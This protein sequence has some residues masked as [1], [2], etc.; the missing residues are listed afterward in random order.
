MGDTDEKGPVR[1][2]RRAGP[3]QGYLLSW[4]ECKGGGGLE[5]EV[6]QTCHVRR[7][8]GGGEAVCAVSSASGHL[9]GRSIIKTHKITANLATYQASL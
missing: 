7:R 8:P 6:T 5:G 9:N 4:L 2:C 3:G 1:V